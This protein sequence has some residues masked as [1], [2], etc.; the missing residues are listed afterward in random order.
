MFASF[1]CR[2]FSRSLSAAATSARTVD[3]RTHTQQ[4]LTLVTRLLVA[5][6]VVI[7]STSPKT[8][9]VQ[10]GGTS[11]KRVRFV[12]VVVGSV[13]VVD[14]SGVSSDGLFRSCLLQRLLLM[15]RLWLRRQ[16]AVLLLSIH[17]SC[18][19]VL[20]YRGVAGLQHRVWNVT[21]FL[22]VRERGVDA[23]LLQC[24]APDLNS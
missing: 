4:Q 22:D 8:R 11:A 12:L 15:Q 7:V 20:R 6:R 18:C 13:S 9:T 3:T 14:V 23:T 10:A 21:V 19:F 1:A 2:L 17:L 5:V 16:L 24:T